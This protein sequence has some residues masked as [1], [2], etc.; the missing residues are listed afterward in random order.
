MAVERIRSMHHIHSLTLV[1]VDR[2][3]DRSIALLVCE[4]MRFLLLLL[5]LLL[6]PTHDWYMMSSLMDAIRRMGLGLLSMEHQ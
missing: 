2:S 3:I 6:L 1:V 4:R 5:L